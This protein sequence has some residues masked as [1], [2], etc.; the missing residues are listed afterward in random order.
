MSFLDKVKSFFS[1]ES[2]RNEHDHRHLQSPTHPEPDAREPT[3]AELAAAAAAAPP[4]APVGPHAADDQP[5]VPPGG[6]PAYEGLDGPE[7]G[8]PLDERRDP[9]P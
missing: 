2:E 3:E 9:A 7:E 5:T 6:V 4:V 1:G 8:E